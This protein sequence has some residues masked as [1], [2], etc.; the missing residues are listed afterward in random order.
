VRRLVAFLL[1]AA[2]ALGVGFAA[3]SA[4]ILGDDAS[5]GPSQ[6][7][8]DA[9]DRAKRAAREAARR[10]GAEAAERVPARR[11]PAL[12]KARCPG[13]AEPSCRA[14][15][16][17][18]VY[19]ERVDP[20]GDGDLHVVVADGSITAPGLTSVDVRPGLRPDRDPHVGDVATAAGP[21]Q[22]GS[23]GQSQVHALVFRVVRAP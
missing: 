17:R 4:A 21:V 10:A 23:I 18:I 20:D 15:R 22:R 16:G 12:R 11:A 14:V 3:A 2:L 13:D 19:V 9:G 1:L 7:A 5:P 8:R 6:A